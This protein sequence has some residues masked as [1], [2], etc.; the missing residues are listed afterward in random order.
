VHPQFKGQVLLQPQD[1]EDV[2]AHLL[3]LKP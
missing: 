3:N 2:V 1:I